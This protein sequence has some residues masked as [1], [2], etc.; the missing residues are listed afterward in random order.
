MAKYDH[1][2]DVSPALLI[3]MA[4][5]ERVMVPIDC[6]RYRD[7]GVHV[8]RVKYA[9][10]NPTGTSFPAQWTKYFETLDGPGTA[11]V[12]TGIVGEIRLGSLRPT[13]PYYLHAAALVGHDATLTYRQVA[14]AAYQMPGENGYRYLLAAELRGPGNFA[15]QTQGNALTMTLKAGET[16]RTVPHALLSFTWGVT[17]RVN[18][19]GGA[20]NFPSMHYFPLVDITGPGTVMVHSG[21]VFEGG[22]EA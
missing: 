12:S 14:L 9:F 1:V 10:P 20:P 18:I 15:Y 17:V 3:Q 22:P 7:P 2:G 8:D 11:T 19:F 4:A 13:E 5:G 6:V 21:E 16:I